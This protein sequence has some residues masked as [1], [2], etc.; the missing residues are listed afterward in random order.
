MRSHCLVFP[1]LT[2]NVCFVVCVAS[3]EYFKGEFRWQMFAK[4]IESSEVNSGNISSI[5]SSFAKMLAHL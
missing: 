5:S 3:K 4:R 1:V 2:V